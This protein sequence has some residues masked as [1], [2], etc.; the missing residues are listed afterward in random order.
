MDNGQ[1][2]GNSESRIFRNVG[3]LTLFATKDLGIVC[4][5]GNMASNGN[6]LEIKVI[7]IACPESSVYAGMTTDAVATTAKH[8]G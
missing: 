7:I 3:K 4:F 5:P 2:Y 8:D 6:H 1:R